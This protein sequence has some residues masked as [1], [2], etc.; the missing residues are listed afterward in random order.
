[1][2]KLFKYLI[3][4]DYAIIIFKIVVFVNVFVHF[5]SESN[6][7][8]KQIFSSY[9]L[10]FG[11]YAILNGARIFFR[12]NKYLLYV[13][14]ALNIDYIF[15]Y[16]FPHQFRF[17]VLTAMSTLIVLYPLRFTKKEIEL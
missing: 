7:F 15:L 10:P 14:L 5:E 8:A 9:L 6:S 3:V 2:A 11:S 12:R 16:V 4:L 1:M 17:L 13:E